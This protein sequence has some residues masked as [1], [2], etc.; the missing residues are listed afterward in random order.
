MRYIHDSYESESVDGPMSKVMSSMAIGMLL[1]PLV[2]GLLA[3][4]FGVASVFLCGAVSFTLLTMALSL[5]LEEVVET[6]VRI[7]IRI[8]L[9]AW[10][11]RRRA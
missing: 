7:R 10:D 1:G 8:R 4:V 2:G 11:F 5:S 3:Q 6:R 9:R